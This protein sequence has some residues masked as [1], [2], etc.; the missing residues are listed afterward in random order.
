MQRRTLKIHEIRDPIHT[1]IKLNS[2][3]RAVVDSA[4]Y[5]RLRNIHQLA[6]TFLVYP[7]AT[8]TRF[9]HCLGVMDL[10]SRIFDVVTTE[11]NLAEAPT[12]LL[13][14]REMFLYWRQVLRLAAL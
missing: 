1:F 8:H 13:P 3:E 4:P 5:Q 12:E 2:H 9:E 14:P 10:A 11:S 6:L 7:G